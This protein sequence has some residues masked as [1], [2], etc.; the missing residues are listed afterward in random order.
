M[1]ECKA[2]NCWFRLLDGCPVMW[3]HFCLHTAGKFTKRRRTFGLR[4]IIP[5]ESQS[6]RNWIGRRFGV[7]RLVGVDVGGE[8]DGARADLFV[9]RRSV[10]Q[11]RRCWLP[12]P[13]VRVVDRLTPVGRPLYG[14]ISGSRRRA[15]CLRVDNQAYAY[16]VRCISTP[17]PH[18]CSAVLPIFSGPEQCQNK[19]PSCRRGPLLVLRLLILSAHVY[20]QKLHWKDGIDY[21][22]DNK[23]P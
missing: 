8:G 10:S 18:A 11:R 12:V 16:A 5:D 14:A 3:R 2:M 20:I 19:R 4:P 17:L 9:R 7:G 13:A 21:N 23:R 6:E 15:I 22:V 1:S